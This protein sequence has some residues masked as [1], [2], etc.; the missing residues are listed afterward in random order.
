MENPISM[1]RFFVGKI[2][3]IVKRRIEVKLAL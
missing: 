1:R 2:Y 3:F